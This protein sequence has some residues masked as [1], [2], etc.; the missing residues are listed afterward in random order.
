MTAPPGTATALVTFSNAVGGTGD[1]F[2]L[3]EILVLDA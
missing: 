2:Y 3:D 1:T